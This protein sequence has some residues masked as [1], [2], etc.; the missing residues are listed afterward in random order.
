[1]DV[2]VTKYEP[3][4]KHA[5]ADAYI[6]IAYNNNNYEFVVEVKNVD[7]FATI[8]QVKHQL[9]EFNWTSPALVDV[10]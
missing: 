7:R 8:A 6:N 1:M 10:Y 4:A 3:A 9:E 2:E 5:R